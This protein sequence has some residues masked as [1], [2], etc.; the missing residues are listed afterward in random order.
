MRRAK[1][2][3][4]AGALLR[5]W[6]R[7]MPAEPMTLTAAD[8]VRLD[9]VLHTVASGSD[10]GTIIQVHG[11]AADMDEGGMYARLA[12]RLA[13][14]GFTV[15]RFSFR[16]HGSSGGSQRGATIAGELLDLQ[17][18][19]DIVRRGCRPPLAIIAASFGAVPVAL[20]LS[21]LNDLA[22]LVLWNPVLD[23]RRTF[24]EP[25]LPWGIANFGPRQQEDLLRTGSLSID[26]AFEL[27]CILFEEMKLYDPRGAFVRSR[28]RTLV[29]H[30]DR[31]SYVSY[32]IA[33][34]AATEQGA[35]DFHTVHGS[36]HGFDSAEREEEAVSVTVEWLVQ[37]HVR[38]S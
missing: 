21:H 2:D 32:A 27:G 36:D 8:S 24:V 1:V 11:I 38:R 25:D 5:G 13:G 6:N 22:S 18:A 26:G 34:A 19:V 9:A 30:G 29:V 17:A 10:R 16:G 31:D 35:A 4:A 33:R 12:G 20:S 7:D 23:L 15:L 37:R 28:V 3:G 14:E